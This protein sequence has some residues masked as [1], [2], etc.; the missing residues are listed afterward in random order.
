[1]TFYKAGAALGPHLPK[2][3]LPHPGPNYAVLLTYEL[4]ILPYYYDFG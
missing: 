3:P 2:W 4:V 1:M